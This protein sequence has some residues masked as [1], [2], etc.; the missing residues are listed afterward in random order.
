MTLA[1]LLP[2]LLPLCAPTGPTQ[3]EAAALSVAP[4]ASSESQVELYDLRALGLTRRPEGDVTVQSLV[5]S[6]TYDWRG[7]TVEEYDV[8]GV[9]EVIALLDQLGG[10]EFEFEGRAL[11]ASSEEVLA[12]RAPAAMQA[13]VAK[14]LELISASIGRRV[15]VRVDIINY[16]SRVQV[17]PTLL[18]VLTPADAE[19][20][21]EGAVGRGITTQA[22]SLNVTPGELSGLD[23]SSLHPLL[24]DYDVEVA[25]S[26]F[27]FDPLVID[28]I[29]G[30]RIALGC[31]PLEGGMG[32]TVILRSGDPTGPPEQ[33]DLEQR[34][35]TSNETVH[36]YLKGPR[37]VQSMPIASRSYAF[38]TALPTGMA[39]TFQSTLTLEG[40]ESTQ[41]I[42]IEPLGEPLPA[43]LKVATTGA[44]A[45]VF[46]VNLDALSQQRMAFGGDLLWLP[47]VKLR[48]DRMHWDADSLL[49]AVYE[50]S[51]YDQGW[52]L[53]EPH[54]VDLELVST[55][56]WLLATRGPESIEAARQAGHSPADLEGVVHSFMQPAQ[57]IQLS[58]KLS[59]AGEVLSKGLS[60]DLP[61][62]SGQRSAIALGV[63]GTQ[64]RDFDVEIAKGATVADPVVALHLDGLILL[65]EPHRT[66]AGDLRLELQGLAQLLR[67][68]AL[69]EPD[70]PMF[71]GLD[72]LLFDRLVIDQSVT[73][74]GGKGSITLGD[75]SSKARAGSLRLDL[76]V[77]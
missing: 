37:Y 21:R 40:V 46:A 20:L 56:N 12:V 5:P 15:Q 4:L 8:L 25:S 38:E 2:L 30:T 16:P 36:E 9:D 28:L 17:D 76:D 27:A 65:I 26:A 14:L 43:V 6:S 49:E 18:G 74:E 33:V 29:S 45:D 64:V 13:R 77:R 70:Y 63:E 53:L 54:C 22:L 41:V 47:A 61:L 35:F 52:E 68:R 67:E 11:W 57:T 23:R 50:E 44:S 66:P 1:T 7:H 31:T 72:Q 24:I 51:D 19:R 10:G 39:L 69:F 73:L 75:S 62:R 34:G 48:S 32:L 59:H 55:S 71:R 60:V 3:V 42:I 58:V